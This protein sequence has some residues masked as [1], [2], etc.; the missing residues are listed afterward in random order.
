VEATR[1]AGGGWRIRREDLAAFVERRRQPAVRV[2]FDIT[3]TTEKSISVLALL[4]GADVRAEILAAVREAN[5]TG[6]R[7]LERHAAGARAGKEI[8]AVEGRRVRLPGDVVTSPQR[9]ARHYPPLRI[10]GMHPTAH[11][12]DVGTKIPRRTEALGLQAP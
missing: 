10:A 12:S 2:G 1:D 6:M 3:A 9:P 7:W 5:N 4:G 8:L 11:N